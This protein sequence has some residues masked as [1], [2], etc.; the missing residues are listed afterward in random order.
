MSAKIVVSSSSTWLSGW[1]RPASAGVSRTG[2]VTSRVSE[3]SRASRAADFSTSR[4]AASA[5][6]TLSLARLIAAPWVLRSSGDILPRVASSAEIEPFLPR[7]ATRTAS[8]A[9]SS[10]AA[11]I[12]LRMVCSSVARSDTVKS[13]SQKAAGCRRSRAETSSKKPVMKLG[14][15]NP[16][17]ACSD[18]RGIPRGILAG[19]RDAFWTRFGRSGRHFVA[20]H[21]PRV[22]G[23]LSEHVD[24]VGRG[25]RRDQCRA[26]MRA[27]DEDLRGLLARHQRRHSNGSRRREQV[28]GRLSRQAQGAAEA[29]LSARVERLRPKIP[30]RI[31]HHVPL[32]HGLL[33]RADFTALL[34]WGIEGSEPVM[35]PLILLPKLP[36]PQAASAALAFSAIAWNA[37]G[38]AMARS[39]STLRSTRMPDLARPLMNT[40]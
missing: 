18:P 23:R 40:L 16:F 4:R 2:S 3:A 7:A 25:R 24:V 21:Q 12:W 35:G 37:A 17:G 27:C 9:G 39:D 13:L 34:A 10:P 11:A 30:E 28:R 29:G 6:L 20:R 8:S 15:L 1:I 26:R 31:R 38:S 14:L 36:V 19:A 22:S 33:P 32:V 5:W